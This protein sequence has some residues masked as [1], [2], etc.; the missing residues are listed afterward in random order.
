MK[1]PKPLAIWDRTEGKKFEEWMDDSPDTYETIPQKSFSQRFRAHILYAALIGLYQGSPL[2]KREI[3]PFIDKY[4]IDM[5]QF[6]DHDYS[7]YDDFFIRK[8]KPGERAFPVPSG[9]LGAFAEA[10]YFGWEKFTA[11]Q[12]FPVKGR[13]LN[14]EQMLGSA[15][16]ARPFV[17]GPLIVARLSPVDYHHVHYPDAGRTLDRHKMG[18]RLWTVTWTAMQNKPDLYI[19]NEREIQILETENFGRLAIVEVGA[20]TVGRIEQV[21]PVDQAFQRGEQKSVFHFGGSAVVLF[22][23]PG[24]WRPTDDLLEHTQEGVE[25]LVKLGDTVAK[26]C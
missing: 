18:R 15:E 4:H 5:S 10:R 3:K 14:A 16:R 20:L 19:E 22:G 8:F 24:A 2:S 23:E 9:E 7:S 25:T 1:H 6:E 26:R 21:H 11:E 13:S 12:Q 17:D